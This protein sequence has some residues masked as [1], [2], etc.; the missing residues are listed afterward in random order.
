LLVVIVVVVERRMWRDE[1]SGISLDIY[2]ALREMRRNDL[3]VILLPDSRIDVVP[4]SNAVRDD[5][6]KSSDFL[7]SSDTP[8]VESSE[9]PWE[10]TDDF[11]LPSLV[12]SPTLI[13]KEGRGVGG[14]GAG[15][16]GGV[17]IQG[18]RGAG[19]VLKGRRQTGFVWGSQRATMGKTGNALQKPAF[20]EMSR[21][22][23][24]PRMKKR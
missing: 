1:E 13:L 19:G 21:V 7:T 10:S 17:G 23:K 15:G 4:S 3:A 24:L 11:T 5:V 22:P 16:R 6:M 12:E 9:R 8:N 2:K 18:S 14:R 20:S